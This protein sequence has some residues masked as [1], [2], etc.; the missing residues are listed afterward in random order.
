MRLLLVVT[1][2]LACCHGYLILQDGAYI[3][4]NDANGVKTIA[5]STRNRLAFDL[6]TNILYNVGK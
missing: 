5:A 3:R 4:L 2:W 6:F 1:I